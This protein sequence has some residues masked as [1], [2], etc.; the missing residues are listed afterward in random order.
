MPKFPRLLNRGRAVVLALLASA[1]ALSAFAQADPPARIGRIAWLSGEVFLNN[2]ETGELAAAPLNQPL[3]SG[4]ILTTRPGARAEVQI[5]A[6]T[7]R[8]DA[9]T[10]LEFERIDDQQIRLLLNGGRVIAKLPT[11]DTRHDFVLESDLGRFTPRE[12]GIYRFDRDTAGTSATS[13]FGTLRFEGRDTAFDIGAGESARTWIDQGGQLRYQMAQGVRDEFTQWSAARDQGQR[14]SVTARYVSPEVTGAQD[15]DAYG[16][17]SDQPE[18]GAVWFPRAVAADWAPY[19]TGNWT[20]VAPWGWTWIGYE[21]WGFAPFHYGRWAYVSNRWGWVPGARAVRPVYAPALVGW[22]GA[23]G[24]G[25]AV[26]SAPPVGWFPLAPREV[27]VPFYRSSPSYVRFVNAPHVSHIRNVGEIVTRPRDV[28]RETRFSYRDD[29]R[30]SGRMPGNAYRRG[31]PGF[32]DR[33]G[34]A[35]RPD[36]RDRQQII[37]SR[38]ENPRRVSEPEQASRSE[39]RQFDASPAPRQQPSFPTMRRELP[40]FDSDRRGEIP[41][42][43]QELPARRDAVPRADFPRSGQPAAPAMRDR[44]RERSQDFSR[45][46]RQEIRSIEAP[47]RRDYR[48]QPTAWDRPGRQGSEGRPAAGDRRIDSQERPFRRGDPPGRR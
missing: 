24:V 10:R 37:D 29:P 18:Y 28:M 30:A 25:F 43:R 38:L 14:S 16:D 47:G 45:Q 41:S 21:P 3:T 26:R 31:G 34:N 8:L 11:E 7:L 19:Q 23:P 4:D 1:F 12:T 17:W 13:Y 27:Y 5:G 46:Q 32:D 22:A 33:P 35:G 6:M 44:P 40:R 39:R 2:P 36:F 9:D 42:A 48:A 20:W 15:L